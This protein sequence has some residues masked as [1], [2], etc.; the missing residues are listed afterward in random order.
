MLLVVFTMDVVCSWLVKGCLRCSFYISELRHITPF[1]DLMISS[2]YYLCNN[3]NQLSTKEI[4]SDSNIWHFHHESLYWSG[5][6]YWT[7]IAWFGE[8][9][10]HFDSEKGIYLTQS[11][12]RSFYTNR[13][14]WKSK[15]TTQQMQQKSHSPH[16]PCNQKVTYLNQPPLMTK[17]QVIKSDTQT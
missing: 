5:C 8:P 13:T 12:V 7:K 14:L 11:F 3:F 4:S 16:Q 6:N 17:Y 1:S 10:I 9:L 15:A 2:T